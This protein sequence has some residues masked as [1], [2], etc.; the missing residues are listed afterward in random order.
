A[1]GCRIGEFDPR[2]VQQEVRVAQRVAVVAV[3]R[4]G[5]RIWPVDRDVVAQVTAA[6]A[7]IHVVDLDVAVEEVLLGGCGGRREG[8]PRQCGAISEPY[9]E[10]V[11]MNQLFDVLYV[12]DYD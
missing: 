6:R 12:R 10:I 5:D 2:A 8:V 9:I 4:Q 7:L 1:V 3:W 11:Q